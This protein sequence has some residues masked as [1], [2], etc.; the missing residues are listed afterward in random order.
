MII[1][2]TGPSGDQAKGRKL[3]HLPAMLVVAVPLDAVL[4]GHDSPIVHRKIPGQTPGGKSLLAGPMGRH[5][6]NGL[7]GNAAFGQAVAAHDPLRVGHDDP[8]ARPGQQEGGGIGSS[9]RPDGQEIDLMNS[10]H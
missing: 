2:K 6:P 8:K 3:C 10:G 5:L 9:P 7:G 1:E 4:V